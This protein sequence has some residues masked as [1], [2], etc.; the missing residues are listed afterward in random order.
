MQLDISEEHRQ[1]GDIVQGDFVDSY[2]NLTLKAMLALKWATMHCKNAAFFLKADDDIVFNIFKWMKIAERVSRQHSRMLM[3]LIYTTMEIVRDQPEK[4]RVDPSEFPGQNVY[5]MYCSGWAWTISAQVIPELYHAAANTPFFW[6]DDVFLTGLAAA[7]LKDVHYEN[8]ILSINH[9]ENQS[10]LA[11]HAN[12]DQ[13]TKLWSLFLRWHQPIGKT[14]VSRRNDRYLSAA[15]P[16]RP[17]T[18]SRVKDGNL[19][20]GLRVKL[21]GVSP[22][23]EGKKHILNQN[24]SVNSSSVKATPNPVP[25]DVNIV[26]YDPTLCES[27]PGLRWVFYVH[28]APEHRLKRDLIRVTW[29]NPAWHRSGT[30]R[31]VFML[32]QTSVPEKQVCG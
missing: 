23:K 11:E 12:P 2:R 16:V 21:T 5:P 8:V 25:I 3:C 10:M 27:C 6:I 30:T 24:Q 7:K 4:W 1:H 26:L 18:I 14:P 29:G 13:F 15:L 19:S 9:A 28:S 31:L 32:G 17:T 22:G 20:V